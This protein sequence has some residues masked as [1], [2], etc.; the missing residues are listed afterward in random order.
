MPTL[1]TFP[2]E[3]LDRIAFFLEPQ[4]ISQ[5]QLTCNSLYHCLGPCML[6]HAV[7][8]KDDMHAL[9]W[10]AGK[11]YQPLVERLLQLFP[12]DL[13]S[14]T[15][16]TA[17]QISAGAPNNQAVL[18]HL[19]LH[20]A[21]V[22]HLDDKGCTALHYVFTEPSITD[23]RAEATVRLLLAHGADANNPGQSLEKTPLWYCIDCKFLSTGR[24]LLDAGADPNWDDLSDNSLLDLLIYYADLDWLKLLLEYRIDINKKNSYQLDALLFAVQS[25]S[26]E[27]VKFFVESGANLR[28]VDKDGNTPLMLAIREEYRENA[29]YLVTLDGVDGTWANNDGQTAAN[30]VAGMG[31]DLVLSK[32]LD[33]GYPVDHVDQQGYT[34]LHIAVLHDQDIIIQTLLD[35]GAN[36]EIVDRSG[37]TPLLLAIRGSCLGIVE[38]LVAEG[39]DPAGCGD[40]R[41]PPLSVA[42]ELGLKGIVTVL[43][44]RGVDINYRDEEGMTPMM[45]AEIQGYDW[46]VEIL[47]ANGGIF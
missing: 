23:E 45:L 8:P 4:S 32:L 44:A 25:E 9:H 36:M 24:V 7:A 38:I 21:D 41:L 2:N 19:L 3:L 20:G 39:A 15:G 14:A 29:E 17:L 22:N 31:W 11:G 40:G 13:P 30:M 43:L 16:C 27:V 6:R 33:S 47:A 18:T 46:V 5:M 42:C 35:A 12:V 37:C 1:L 10:A 26:L 34:A 28:T